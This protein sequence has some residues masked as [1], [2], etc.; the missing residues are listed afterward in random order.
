MENSILL[1]IKKLLGLDQNYNAFDTDVMI[2]I[3]TVFNILYQLGVSKKPFFIT[4]E[5][6]TWTDYLGDRADLEAVKSLVYLRVRLL[7][8]PPATGVLHEAMERQVKELE[9]R[10]NFAA[11]GGMDLDGQ[12]DDTD[13]DDSNGDNDERT[14]PPR[15]EG[16]EVG[17]SEVEGTTGV[18]GE[19]EEKED[20]GGVSQQVEKEGSSSTSEGGSQEGSGEEEK[21]EDP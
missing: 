3:N 1:S 8:D 15:S 5:T 10:L 14:L 13:S 18:S 2:S 11:E 6:E 9:W 7:F 19:T 12:T 17:S 16:N 20:S 21:T 4:G